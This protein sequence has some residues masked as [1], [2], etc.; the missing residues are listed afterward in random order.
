M[1]TQVTFTITGVDNQDLQILA[2]AHLAQFFN[3]P[4]GIQDI[5]TALHQR[6]VT[7]DMKVTPYKRDRHSWRITEWEAEVVAHG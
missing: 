6:R 1:S 2:E 3:L 7:Y 5:K 4:P